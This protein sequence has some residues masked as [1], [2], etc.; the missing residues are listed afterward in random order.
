[1]KKLELGFELAVAHCHC[2]YSAVSNCERN[3]ESRTV[4]IR[5]WADSNILF[6]SLLSINACEPLLYFGMVK[7][8]DL[9][10]EWGIKIASR[11]EQ[12]GKSDAYMSILKHICCQGLFA[13]VY[14]TR[15]RRKYKLAYAHPPFEYDMD[16]CLWLYILN[17]P[18]HMYD[19]YP[20]VFT[21]ISLEK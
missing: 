12:S 5:R 8:R 3:I 11:E 19:F 15:L 13:G 6:H 20:L 2:V 21:W 17:P 1:M 18:L 16:P 14:L 7:Y 4:T 10:C 9:R